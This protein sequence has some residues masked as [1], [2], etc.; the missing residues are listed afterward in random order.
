MGKHGCH[1]GVALC[2]KCEWFPR[3]RWWNYFGYVPPKFLRKCLLEE[4]V[5]DFVV[6]ERKERQFCGIKNQNGDCH[7]Y[8]ERR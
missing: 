8:K 4:R 6:G 5:K 3:P 7:D 1:K 2:C